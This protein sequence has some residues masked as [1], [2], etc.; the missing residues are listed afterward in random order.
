MQG[1]KTPLRIG[2][3]RL[4][5]EWKLVTFVTFEMELAE[6]SAPV[7]VTELFS[8]N[9]IIEQDG[10]VRDSKYVS[11]EQPV[12]HTLNISQTDMVVLKNASYYEVYWFLNCKYIGKTN[13]LS[14]TMKYEGDDE[15]FNIEALIVSSPD[16]VR[17]F[18]MELLETFF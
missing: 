8:G 15:T 4:K 17:N 6:A 14:L 2:A 16:P 12:T 1:G 7:M 3:H 13:D 5:V 11:V 9:M 10:L 18:L